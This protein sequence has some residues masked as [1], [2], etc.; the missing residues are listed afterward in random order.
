MGT[1]KE[2]HFENW[3]GLDLSYSQTPQDGHPD[4]MDTSIK[5]TPNFGPCYFFQSFTVF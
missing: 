4:K 1:S 5:R 2:I 3:R